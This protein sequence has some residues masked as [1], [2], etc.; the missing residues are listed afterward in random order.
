MSAPWELIR[1]IRIMVSVKIQRDPSPANAK[2][3]TQG[4]GS[5]VKVMKSNGCV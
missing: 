4:M 3:A 1:A 5:R 2:M